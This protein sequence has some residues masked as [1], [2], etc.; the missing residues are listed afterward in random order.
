MTATTKPK[1]ICIFKFLM[2]V[3]TGPHVSALAVEI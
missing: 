2:P 3:I 1:A